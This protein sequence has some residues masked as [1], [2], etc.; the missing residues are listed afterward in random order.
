MRIFFPVS[1]NLVSR[2]CLVIGAAD[3]REAIE[4][5]AA[6]EEAGA[7]VRRIYDG[8]DVKEE[9]VAQAFF[10]ISTPQDAALS[11][12]LRALADKHRTLLCCI[13][14]PAYG[15]VAMAAIAKAGPVRVAI[16]TA[17]L[18]P[19]VGKVL[20]QAVQRAM[21]A[22]FERFIGVLAERREQMR[23]EH[24]LPEESELRRKAAI[25]NAAG[26]TADVCFTYPSW[27]STD[28]VDRNRDPE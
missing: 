8:A 14:Q 9:D 13:D 21:D 15:F 24:P 11:Q 26:F 18:A 28:V 6:L 12:R 10:V 19:R 25:D 17:G 16:S 5:S 4:K 27:L 7:N 20:K 1:L 23:A 3:D 2:P 22:T